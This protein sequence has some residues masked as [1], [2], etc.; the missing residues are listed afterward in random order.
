MAVYS[1]AEAARIRELLPPFED[2]AARRVIVQYTMEQIAE[3]TESM[4]EWSPE[5]FLGNGYHAEVEHSLQSIAEEAAYQASRTSTAT[6]DQMIRDLM[7]GAA[8]PEDFGIVVPESVIRHRLT[9]E[10]ALTAD[11]FHGSEACHAEVTVGPRGAVHVGRTETYRRNGRTQTWKRS[12]S[13]F[14]IPVKYG[15]YDAF[16]I[17]DETPEDVHVGQPEDCQYGSLQSA[18]QAAR[19]ATPTVTR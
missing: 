11:T 2:S 17:T 15:M 8:V 13:R 5:D 18:L 14:S 4:Q 10:E 19:S 1:P 12:P 6:R 7:S 9:M 16:R 3:A